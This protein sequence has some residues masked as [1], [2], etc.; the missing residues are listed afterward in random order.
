MIRSLATLRRDQLDILNAHRQE[1]TAGGTVAVLPRPGGVIAPVV[2]G[3]VTSIVPVDTTYGPHMV[4]ARQRFIGTP[5]QASDIPGVT[6]RCYPT[7]NRAVGDYS[8]GD[9]VRLAPCRGAM[10]A[11]ALV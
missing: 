3:R 7:P 2:Y 5:P 1:R 4:V 10:L 6:V 8:I 9:Y 11:E